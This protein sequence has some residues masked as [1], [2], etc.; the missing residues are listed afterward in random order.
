MAKSKIVSYDLC[1]TDKNYDDLYKYLK[2]F[3]DWAKIT[4]STWFI[5]SEKTCA[6]IRDEIMKIVDSNDRVIVAE[7]TGVAAWCNIICKSEYLKEHL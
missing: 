3:S 5:S 6:T 7:L 1:S 2:S 4:E